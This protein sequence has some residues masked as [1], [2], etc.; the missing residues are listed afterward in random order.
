MRRRLMQA[1]VV[2]VVAFVA[3]QLVRPDRANPPVDPSR[4]IQA[5][6]TTPGLAAVLDRSCGDCHSNAT[7]WPGYAQVAPLS[8]I[9][10]DAVTKGRAAVNF[11]EWTAYSPDQ[12]R[13]LLSVSCDDATSGKMPGAYTYFKPETRLSPDDIRTICGAS[14]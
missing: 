14:H 12:Q 1:A 5:H 11:S 7:V 2:L 9:M 6:A 4:T 13:T 8:W 3:A 10:A